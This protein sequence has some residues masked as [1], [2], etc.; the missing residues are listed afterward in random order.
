MTKLALEDLTF[1]AKAGICWSVFWRGLVVTLAAILIAGLIG[2]IVGFVGGLLG[3]PK[4]ARMI[5]AFISGI[6]VSVFVLYA[7]LRWLLRARLG[8]YRLLLVPADE[9]T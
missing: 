2:F 5:L 9:Q 3:F 8:K 7:N 6:V 4:S 1:I